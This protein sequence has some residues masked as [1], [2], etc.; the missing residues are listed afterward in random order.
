ML[1][2]GSKGVKVKAWQTFLRGEGHHIRIDGDFGPSTDKYTKLWQ[3]AN[4]LTDDGIVGPKTL[5]KSK[6][7][8]HE[9]ITPLSTGLKY[10]NQPGKEKMFGK[11]PFEFA[12]EEGNP[13]NIEVSDEWY[14]ENI[15]RV[16]SDAITKCLDVSSI[17]VHKRVADQ[18]LGVFEDIV[19]AGLDELI[20]TYGGTYSARLQRGSKTKLSS[21]AWA[22]AI[23]INMKQN[24][25]GKKPAAKGEDG[26]VVELA[27]IFEKWGFYW[28][29]NFKRRPDGMHFEVCK[30][31]NQ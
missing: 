3:K 1:K 22:T 25:L 7:S 9:E 31:V 23:D 10:L 16:A 4:G 19:K 5:A 26:S 6:E 13:E 30:I 29:G 21:H 8:G 11:I 2:I 24:G 28:G 18:F 27:P 20:S 12:P 14:K 17:R 15:I